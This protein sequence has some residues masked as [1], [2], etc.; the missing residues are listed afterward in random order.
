MKVIETGFAV[1]RGPDAF[2]IAIG[3]IAT[4]WSLVERHLERLAWILL[5]LPLGE[6]VTGGAGAGANLPLVRRLIELRAPDYT[7]LPALCAALKDTEDLTQQR[8]AVIH[9]LWRALPGDGEPRYLARQSSRK[10][11]V[12]PEYTLAKLH[13]LETRIEQLV[14]ELGRHVRGLIPLYDELLQQIARHPSLSTSP[15]AGPRSPCAEH[16]PRAGHSRGRSQ[17]CRPA[18]G[19]TPPR[20]PPPSKA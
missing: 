5:P 14:G 11:R 9:G 19:R 3:R 15:P 12:S 7:D 8:N 16:R 10:P 4:L 20:R 13:G 18:K 17:S 6:V 2:Y 1:G